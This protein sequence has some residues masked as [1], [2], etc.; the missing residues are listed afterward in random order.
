VTPLVAET[1]TIDGQE[2]RCASEQIEI[3]GGVTREISVITFAADRRPAILRRKSTLSDATGS[4]VMQEVTSEV[5]AID[6]AHRVLDALNPKAAYLVRVDQKNDRGT[7]VTWSWHVP[8]V[9]G[10]IVDQCSKKLDT[11]GRL[12]R[13]TTLEVVA[14]GVGEPAD[15]EQFE[16]RDAPRRESNPRRARRRAK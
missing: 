8:E 11:M 3:S 1:L 7:T 5:K 9:P 4:K 10:E 2:I 13:R 6:M 16:T 12:V 14:Y 15:V